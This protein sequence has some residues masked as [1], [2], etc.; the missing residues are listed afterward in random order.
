M[1]IFSIVRIVEPGA[2]CSHPVGRREVQF[3]APYK[4]CLHSSLTSHDVRLS[5]KGRTDEEAERDARE[6]CETFNRCRYSGNLGF[7]YEVEEVEED[8]PLRAPPK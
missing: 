8:S 3:L 7:R 5:M 1:T 4:P 6:L 2:N